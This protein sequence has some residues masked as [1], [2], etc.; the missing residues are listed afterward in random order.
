MRW[1]DAVA[2]S[3]AGVYVV[4]LTDDPAAL[5]EL[6]GDAPV[7]IEA[8][9][10]LLTVRP[11][12]MLDGVRP[13]T[14]S[15]AARIARFWFPDEVALYIG[16]AGTTARPR[17]LRTRIRDYYTTPLGARKPHAGGWLLKTL[18]NLPELSVHYAQAAD[19]EEAESEM[20]RE[21]CR[22]VSG[23]TLKA[24]RDP[25]RP[26]PFANLEWPIGVRK[27]HGITGAR[28]ELARAPDCS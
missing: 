4:A 6:P 28:G 17:A 11:E 16:R 12:L 27:N 13:K 21:Y 10:H 22:N 25:D 1:G 15:L 14:S 5:L 26:F 7:S 9:D 3:R 23:S 18:E 20:T 2:E 8:V 19:P 24:I